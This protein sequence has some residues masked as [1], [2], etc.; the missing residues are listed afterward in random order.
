MKKIGII[1]I[2]LTMALVSCSK[3][4]DNNTNPLVNPLVG[5]WVISYTEFD[6]VYLD[7]ITFNSNNTGLV[8]N[9]EDGVQVDNFS[10]TWSTNNNILTV[11]FDGE[12]LTTVYS[13]SGNQLTMDGEVY[14][15][16]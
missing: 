8:I 7:E 4:E 9:K 15:R 10:F 13:I 6:V 12:T 16:R 1:L 14:T 5:T 3:D 11:S 2:I